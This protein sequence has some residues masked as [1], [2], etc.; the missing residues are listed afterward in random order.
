M[1]L[2]VLFAPSPPGLPLRRGLSV[3][4]SPSP[5][6]RP[7]PLIAAEPS[8]GKSSVN[9]A[10]YTPSQK[11]I[12]KLGKEKAGGAAAVS[13]SPFFVVHSVLLEGPWIPHHHPPPGKLREGKKDSKLIKSLFFPS[14]YVGGCIHR[15]VQV[16]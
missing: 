4:S 13:G 9:V 2:P 11:Q 15:N 5:P 3:C 8:S 10:E 12:G 6:P 14:I 1:S 16:L 7:T